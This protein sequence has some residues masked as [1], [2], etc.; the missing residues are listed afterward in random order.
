S[1]RERAFPSNHASRQTKEHQDAGPE[2]CP[3]LPRKALAGGGHRGCART[4]AKTSV[5]YRVR[6]FNIRRT[7]RTRGRSLP[8]RDALAPREVDER[9]T[10][11]QRELGDRLGGARW[12]VAHEGL[13]HGCGNAWAAR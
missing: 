9:E 2:V 4:T 11:L 6:S 7:R 12:L 8:D 3:P 1:T 5:P 10:R 13:R